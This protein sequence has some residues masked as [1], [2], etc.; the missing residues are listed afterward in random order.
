MCMPLP[1]LFRGME[2][3]L[4]VALSQDRTL[5]FY[6]NLQHNVLYILRATLNMYINFFP[7]R[8]TCEAEMKAQ[9]K[10]F[11]SRGFVGSR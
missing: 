5:D 9:S 1:R 7:V 2:R 10:G 6:N 11:G 8:K 4:L 3:K